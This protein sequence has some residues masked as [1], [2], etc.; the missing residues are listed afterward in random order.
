MALRERLQRDAPAARSPRRTASLLPLVVGLAALLCALVAAVGGATPIQP[1]YSW[2]PARLPSETPARL[3]YTPL[4]VSRHEPETLSAR[5][6]CT[7]SPAL[8]SAG[9]SVD[10]LTTARDPVRSGAL[11]L[12]RLD[13]RLSVAVGDKTLA[14]VPLG[15]ASGACAYRLDLGHG[16]WS[17][18]GGPPGT[19]AQ[20]TL[21]RMPVVDGLFSELDLRQGQRPSIAVQTDAHGARTGA[22]QAVFW[23]LAALGALAA[24]LLAAFERWPQRSVKGA[25]PWRYIRLE[26]GVVILVLVV[27]L[28]LG[29]AFFDD[30]W[31]IARQRDFSAA[32][33]FSSYYSSFG[34]NLPL[35]YWLEWTQHWLVT[36]STSLL[37]LRLPALALLLVTWGIA[38]WA[39]ARLAGNESSAPRW[40]LAFG[41]LVVALAWGMTLRPEPV[42]A[43][44]VV[45]VLAAVVRFNERQTAGPLALATLLVVLSLSAHPAGIVALAPFL[46]ALPTVAAWVRANVRAS[47]TIVIGAGALLAV[48]LTIGSDLALRRAELTSLR[49]YGDETAGWRDELSRYSFLNQAPY[50][51]PLRR[52]SVALIVLAVAAFV[53]RRRDPQQRV[54]NLPAATLGIS[55]LLLIATPTKWPWHFG[56]LIG[57]AAVA[58][59]TE[60]AR[61]R[62]EGRTAR[63]WELAPIIAIGAAVVAA[64]WTYSPRN[65]WGDLDLRTLSWTLGFERHLTLPKLAAAVPVVLLLGAL[66]VAKL[67]GKGRLELV[68]VP[69]R[70]AT[71]MVPAIAV[72][73]LVFTIGVLAADAVRTKSWTLGRQNLESIAG[74]LRCGLADDEV[75]A[76]LGSMRPLA[77][78][79]SG[80]GAESGPPSPRAHVPRFVLGGDQEG[81][82]WYALPGRP[83]GVFVSGA[84]GTSLELEWGRQAGGSFK[85]AG[86]QTLQA[87]AADDARPDVVYWR[88]VPLP[89]P[90]AGA[91]AVR[92]RSTA[93]ATVATTAPVTYGNTHLVDLL[94]TRSPSLALPN[95][96][97]YVPC[98]QQPR[99]GAVAEPPKAIVAFRNSMWPLGT[100]TSP[101]DGITG[102]YQL[103]RLPLTDSA[104][105]PNEVAVYVVDDRIGG[106]RLLPPET[107][108]A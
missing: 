87:I 61:L 79:G 42:L 76:D 94:E 107:S 90:P 44:L 7:P 96:L 65:G 18:S 17:L 19:G 37:V 98:V 57:V 27:W 62:R 101:F 30:G 73:V 105:K 91:D 38:R 70:V 16:Q 36:N 47:L 5:I 46:A 108:G 20:G 40:A 35:D 106:G 33:G 56:T 34:V 89:Q 55:L 81:S 22:S 1:T 15:T 67:R 26:D 25:K 54:L 29:P 50:G 84:P 3:W 45:G 97:T 64:A 82:G 49:L 43:A 13:D 12:V 78:A 74:D 59:G 51:P 88:F 21:D 58:I 83:V 11:S 80:R 66:L 85:P 68:G 39:F 77:P 60:T 75:V 2:P 6:P 41:F 63:R 31:V 24:L 8:R 4:L 71:W 10:V 99:V 95:L 53:F 72:P 100:G 102:V 93:G 92:L 103:V 69:W 32:G 23:V 9:S 52:E 48:L 28:V 14:V 86:A 104:A